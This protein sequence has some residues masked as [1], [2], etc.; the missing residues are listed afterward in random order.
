MKN[1]IL[2]FLLAVS[3]TAQGQKKPYPIKI[4]KKEVVVGKTALGADIKSISI[5]FPEPVHDYYFDS[6]RNELVT[7]IRKDGTKSRGA[8]GALDL[9]TLQFKWTKE[10][11]SG[12]FD[13]YFDDDKMIARKFG[14][15]AVYERD[16]G[17]KKWLVLGNSFTWV[18]LD[19]DIGL[20]P[21]GWAINLNTGKT[22]WKTKIN[23]QYGWQDL[24]HL[25]DQNILIVAGGIKKINL[26]DGSGWQYDARTGADDYKRTAAVAAVGIAAAVVTGVGVVPTGPDHVTGLCSNIEL[27]SGLIYFA[28]R[29]HIM[30]LNKDGRPRWKTELPEKQTGNSTIWIANGRIYMVNNAWGILNGNKVN[31]GNP[32]IAAFDKKSG[33]TIYLTELSTKDKLFDISLTSLGDTLYAHSGDMLHLYDLVTGQRLLEI[34]A[35]EREL[36][37]ARPFIRDEVF[38]RTSEGYFKTLKDLYPGERFLAGEQGIIRINNK[39]Q[40]VGTIDYNTWILFDKIGTTT[41]YSQRGKLAFVKD[42]LAE[43]VINVGKGG[44]HG[45]LIIDFNEYELRIIDVSS[46]LS[47]QDTTGL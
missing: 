36:N 16:G 34:N 41:V 26:T 19:H 20:S 45:N 47:D 9:T 43:S 6:V 7:I 32:Y 24:Q 1:L 4:E 11:Q 27:D 25:D 29:D 35:R 28:S 15:Q 5:N 2:P 10:I 39:L 22:K 12:R 31:K 42:G 46:L 38:V 3:I 17:K 40:A 30:C 33:K 37:K 14:E 23:S 8:M 13:Y 18:D 44:L 21:N